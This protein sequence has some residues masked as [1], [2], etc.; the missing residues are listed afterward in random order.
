MR[1]WADTSPNRVGH[2]FFLARAVLMKGQGFAVFVLVTCNDDSRNEYLWST[3][4]LSYF[5]NVF[6]I[7]LLHLLGVLVSMAQGS[8]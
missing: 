6:V 3:R 1:V 2:Y 5:A 7:G 4:M 8:A